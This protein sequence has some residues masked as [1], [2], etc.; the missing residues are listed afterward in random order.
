MPDP[1]SPARRTPTVLLVLV[2]AVLVWSAIAPRELSTW[3]METV[4]AIAGLVVVVALWRRFPLTTVL[5]CVLAAARDRARVR[6]A[7]RVR[8]DAAR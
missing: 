1:G 7:H 4:W 6:R 2:T 5:C 8:R 3:F